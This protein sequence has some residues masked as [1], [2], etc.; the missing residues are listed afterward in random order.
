MLLMIG[1]ALCTGCATLKKWP[2]QWQDVGART[3]DWG[4]EIV[5]YE[6]EY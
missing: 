5:G 2:R 4:K 1:A 6:G 3:V